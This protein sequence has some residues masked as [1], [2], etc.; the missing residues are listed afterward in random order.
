MDIYSV[1]YEDELIPNVGTST[2]PHIVEKKIEPLLKQI[3]FDREG[4]VMGGYNRRLSSSGLEYNDIWDLEPTIKIPFVDKEVTIPVSK[5][6]G[7]PFMS[8]GNIPY[9]WAEH[10]KNL[11]NFLES[12]IGDRLAL[13]Q[14]LG[15]DFTPQVSK[16]LNQLEKVKSATP[17]KKYGGFIKSAASQKQEYKY[18]GNIPMKLNKY[19]Y[20]KNMYFPY[21][22]ASILTQ[23]N[24][25]TGEAQ[26]KENT[27]LDKDKKTRNTKP[28]ISNPS[29][30][31]GKQKQ[32]DTAGTISNI[33]SDISKEVNKYTYKP[34]ST[35]PINYNSQI[36]LKIDKNNTFSESLAPEIKTNIQAP[37]VDTYQMSTET[38]LP[39]P[40]PTVTSEQLGQGPAGKTSSFG[41]KAASNAGGSTA[42]ALNIGNQIYNAT[43]NVD[44]RYNQD[45]AGNEKY[46]KE[47]SQAQEKYKEDQSIV[48]TTATTLGTIGTVMSAIPVVNAF[49]WIPAL[50]A[51][52]T[53]AIGDPIVD[54][55]YENN[56]REASLRNF[57]MASPEEY[58]RSMKV[59]NKNILAPESN[60]ARYGGKMFS[61]GG[62]IYANGGNTKPNNTIYVNDPNDPRLQAYQDSLRLYKNIPQT[63]NTDNMNS[64]SPVSDGRGGIDY[65]YYKNEMTNKVKNK[66]AVT[67]DLFDNE[68]N[69]NAYN[70]L[71]IL[72][73]TEPKVKWK[74][75]GN[76]YTQTFEKPVQPVVYQKLDKI[77]TINK[78]IDNTYNNF[79]DLIT[80]PTE[81]VN[82]P[83]IFIDEYTHYGNPNINK[84]RI[85]YENGKIQEYANGGSI[86]M[87]NMPTK[88]LT[89]EQHPWGGYPIGGNNYVEGGEVIL[90]KPDGGKYIFSNRLSYK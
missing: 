36:D 22:G 49:S 5:F 71:T 82:T 57:N 83:K 54:A 73:K 62:N 81:K 23:S 69:R 10:Q 50:L 9:T 68:K 29:L 80:R 4:N 21:G 52:G 32:V 19:N 18:G 33:G 26:A 25:E 76:K 44:D 30:Y 67:S 20:G 90:D 85:K 11:T 13:Q 61:Y 64:L 47:Y 48:D 70:R 55:D 89:H 59:S 42:T 14:E 24:L 60:Q 58:N 41:S 17:I 8:H 75:N 53:K 88:G 79:I 86:G 77:K 51:A 56:A 40:G 2:N 27:V 37:K 6:I 78:P 87:F 35:T 65:N 1:N 15:L 31:S 39:A 34:I 84:G 45:L 38:D 12:K 16:F 66:L 7:K 28:V 72:N 63:F 46:N 74:V 43:K 3:T